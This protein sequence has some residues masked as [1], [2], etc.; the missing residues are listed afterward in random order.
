MLMNLFKYFVILLV[1]LMLYYIIPRKYRWISLFICSIIYYYL[2]SKCLIIYA[3]ISALSIYV[4]GILINKVNDRKCDSD[5]KELKREFKRKNKT[6]KKLILSLCLLINIGLLIYLKY[7]NFLVSSVNSIFGL[8]INEP[9]SKIVLPLGISYYTLMA[10]SYITDVYRGKYKASNNPFKVILYIIFF[11]SVQEGPIARFDDVGDKIYNGNDFNYNKIHSGCMLI[12]FGL[13]KKMVIADRVGI[14]VNNIFGT[15]IGGISVLLAMI[16]YTIQIYAEFSGFM[17]MAIGGA[18]LFGIDLPSNFNR[19]FLSKSVEEFWRR[20]HITLGTFLKDYVF[21]PIS[22]SKFN[23]KLSAFNNKHLSKYLCKF[24]MSAVP[25]FFVWF[26]NGL[27]HGASIKYIL[28]GLY[29]YIIM[30]IGLLLEPL[31]NKLKTDKINTKI[32]DILKV[33][34]TW[35]FVIIGMTIFRATSLGEAFKMVGRIFT[36]NSNGI[37]SYGLSIIDF[38]I[39]ILFIILLFFIAFKEEK[40]KNVSEDI[41]NSFPFN[42]YLVYY[43]LIVMILVFGIYGP[44]YNASDFIYGQF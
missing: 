27:W 20:W 40:G 9:F 3:L 7:S 16:L 37:M 11:P 10:I 30:M 13:F 22:L 29:Y 19:P 39:V 28:Y 6:Y 34:R 21:Y 26:L 14:F 35:I 44:G 5:D 41:V 24:F 33:I 1:C 31:F 2:M 36:H 42:K 32:L 18:K 12:L 4:F 23:M 17:D 25:L 15:E 38:I 8:N 43:I